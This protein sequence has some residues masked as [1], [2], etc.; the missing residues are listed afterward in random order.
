M[1]RNAIVALVLLA[2]ASVAGCKD[3]PAETKV[4]L[5]ATAAVT[6]AAAAAPA[7][8]ESTRRGFGPPRPTR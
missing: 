2:A 4:S 5:A 1:A 3:E 7:P 8:A 6:T